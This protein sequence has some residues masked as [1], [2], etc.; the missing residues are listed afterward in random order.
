MISTNSAHKWRTSLRYWSVSTRISIARALIRS[1]MRFGKWT[2]R[3]AL[4]IA[5]EIEGTR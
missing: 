5:P 2:A 1:G 4:W 3:V